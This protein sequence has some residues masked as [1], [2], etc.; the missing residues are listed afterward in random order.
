M[1]KKR[2]HRVDCDKCGGSYEIP[3]QPYRGW[4][5]DVCGPVVAQRRSEIAQRALATRQ[6]RY[7]K[8]HRPK[9]ASELWSRFAH[10]TVSTAVRYGILPRLDGTIACVD[11]GKAAQE[12]DHRDYARPLEVA[13][14]CKSCN[15][16]RGTASWPDAGQI[17]FQRIPSEEAA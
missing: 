1:A 11:C 3:Y 5:C 4:L 15:R 10:Y 8:L 16:R 9:H 14:V 12:Y 7:P 2:Y 6:A 17:Q 13:P